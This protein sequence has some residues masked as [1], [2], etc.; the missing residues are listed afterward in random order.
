MLQVRHQVEQRFTERRERDTIALE[1]SPD[2]T[3]GG[4]PADTLRGDQPIAHGGF[5]RAHQD[6]QGSTIASQRIQDANR[7][8]ITED[9]ERMEHE[10][11][12]LD[13]FPV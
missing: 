13:R 2:E 5:D 6:L 11:P 8:W 9:A 4:E 7:I 10:V 12:P 3:G 1:L